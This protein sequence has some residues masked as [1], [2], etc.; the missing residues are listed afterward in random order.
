MTLI[1]GQCKGATLTVLA[2]GSTYK[3]N[4][5]DE[6]LVAFLD[7]LRYVYDKSDAGGL[8][9]KLYKIVVVIKLVHIF[10]NA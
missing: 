7:Q 5:N 10:T 6:N 8:S 4:C 2:L 3:D 9:Y 1:C